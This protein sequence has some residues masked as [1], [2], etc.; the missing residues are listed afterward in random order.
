MTIFQGNIEC[1]VMKVIRTK[2]AEKQKDYDAGVKE[3]EK[4]L[5]VKRDEL[6]DKLVN[7]IIGKIL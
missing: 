1:R 2:I 7:S 5:E 6:A 4:E 3:L